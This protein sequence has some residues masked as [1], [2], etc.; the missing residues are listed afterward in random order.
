M[1][2]LGTKRLRDGRQMLPAGGYSEPTENQGIMDMTTGE[3]IALSKKDQR[4]AD[5]KKNKE[6]IMKDLQAKVDK[7]NAEK[8]KA[9][10]PKSEIEKLK[11]LAQ[12]DLAEIQEMKDSFISE[13][14][15]AGKSM[16]RANQTF[17]AIHGF[18]GNTFGDIRKNQQSGKPDK[19][20]ELIESYVRS[21]PPAEGRLYRGMTLEK[22]DTVENVVR[23]IQSGTSSMASWTNNRSVAENFSSPADGTAIIMR[24]NNNKSGAS[25]ENFSV[26]PAEQEVLVPSKV[27]YRLI[28][29][30]EVKQGKDTYTILDFEEV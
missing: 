4:I 7:E 5:A 22:G 27:K 16:L 26:H 11:A 18:T 17:N 3:I 20:A 9:S 24:V 19:R 25:I 6:Q 8:E 30:R 28:K 10:K 12:S 13:Q 21:A 29:Q 15:K 23:R 14:V 2:L 1:Q